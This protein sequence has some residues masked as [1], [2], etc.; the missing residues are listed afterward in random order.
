MKDEL[1]SIQA[2]RGI[3]ALLVVF[4]H[5]EQYVSGILVCHLNNYLKN[6]GSFG[7]DIFFVINGFIMVY[8]NQANFGLKKSIYPFLLKR[9][10]RIFPSY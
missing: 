6:F 10:I 9:F 8:I 5:S 3:A 7:V 2:L 1:K 4:C